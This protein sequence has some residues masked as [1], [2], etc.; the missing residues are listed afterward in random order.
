MPVDLHEL[1]QSHGLPINYTSACNKN[2]KP[3]T[4]TQR[5]SLIGN[6]FCAHTITEKLQSLSFYSAS[7]NDDN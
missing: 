3:L 7:K 2:G 4:R 1:E 6:G 5:L